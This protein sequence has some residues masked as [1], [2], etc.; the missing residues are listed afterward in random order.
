MVAEGLRGRSANRDLIE[1]S[2]PLRNMLNLEQ[3][4]ALN[5]YSH[6]KKYL[7]SSDVILDIGSGNGLVANIIRKNVG[8]RV[9]CLDITDT[10]KTKVKPILFCGKHIPFCCDAFTVTICCFVLHHNQYQKEL[11]DEMKRVTKSKII[12]LEDVTET[13]VDNFLVLCHKFYSGIQYKS[14]KMR[15]RS[16]NEWRDLYTKC[17]LIVKK[18]EKV[19]KTREITYPVSRRV[20]VLSKAFSSFK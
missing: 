16:N 1:I 15:F 5:T 17:G 3:R 12:I 11:L 18:E 20:Y 2:W 9:I 6:I 14:H 7:T 13:I 19:E 10:S 8:A 4:I